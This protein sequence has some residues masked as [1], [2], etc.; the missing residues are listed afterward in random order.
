M[1]SSSKKVVFPT[2]AVSTSSCAIPGL[3]AA[4][5]TAPTS[6]AAS[7]LMNHACLTRSLDTIRA[8]SR[9]LDIESVPRS[10]NQLIGDQVTSARGVVTGD[11]VPPPVKHRIGLAPQ[12]TIA[13]RTFHHVLMAVRYRPGVKS[14][15]RARPIGQTGPLVTELVGYEVGHLIFQ[16]SVRRES[17]AAN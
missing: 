16:L 10:M 7:D 17:G 6:S 1:G 11:L 13:R 15:V 3:G 4:V 8:G 5:T 12:L 14:G 9:Y 2:P